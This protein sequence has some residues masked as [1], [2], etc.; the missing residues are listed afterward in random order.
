M[1]ISSILSSMAIEDAL[2]RLERALGLLSIDC[3]VI[4]MYSSSL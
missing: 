1:A 3:R 2:I 4:E